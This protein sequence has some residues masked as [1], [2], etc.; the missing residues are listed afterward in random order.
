MKI[1]M[2]LIPFLVSYISSFLTFLILILVSISFINF[3]IKKVSK[4][5]Y[6][7]ISNLS[8]STYKYLALTY[9]FFSNLLV[10][11]GYLFIFKK[12]I[13][14]AIITILTF[15]LQSIMLGNKRTLYKL[16]NKFNNRYYNQ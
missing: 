16:E 14:I 7:F 15:I 11:L 10:F 5:T 6:I 8:F 1:L 4:K 2:Y 12:F 9:L 3:V 13:L